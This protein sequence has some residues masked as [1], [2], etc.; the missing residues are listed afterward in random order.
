MIETAYS[1]LY[2]TVLVFLGIAAVACL[3]RTITGKLT[4]DKFIG[5]NMITTIVVIAICV[6]A[7]M[8]GESYLPDVAIVYVVLSFLAVMLLCKIYINLFYKKRGGKK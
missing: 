4:V 5:I 8:F 2:G 7:V 6:L 3:I 1:V